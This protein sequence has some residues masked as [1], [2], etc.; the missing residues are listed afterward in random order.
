M[1]FNCFQFQAQCRGKPLEVLWSAPGFLDGK[2]RPSSSGIP[3]LFP[4]PGRI[5]KGVF[6]WREK[7]YQLPPADGRGNAIHGFVM[8][9][10]WRILQSDQDRVVGEFHAATD[11][12][13]LLDMWPADFRIRVAYTLHNATLSSVLTIDNPG[14]RP[15]PFGLG[16]HPYFRLPLG[17]GTAD[18]C[19]VQLPVGD[20]WELV[21]LLPTGKKLALE[22]RETL[23]RGT[24]F[25]DL[26]LDNVF[27]SLVFEGDWCRS[28]I[29]DP[30]SGVA[31]EQAFDRLF[32]ECVVFTPPHREALCIEPYTCVP[33][34]L[35]LHGV[36]AGLRVLD[37]GET[38]TGRIDISVREQ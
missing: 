25:R 30:G 36:N 22:N 2:A 16:T 29:R 11:D 21:E 18:E 5:P 38:A 7:Q 9:R 34:A 31:V 28:A 17:G 23:Q 15:L 8:S 20:E 37:P 13:S 27:S 19:Q 12:S 10:P 24:P 4:F 6:T 35:N 1:G 3:I 26:R 14:S 33:G 32:R